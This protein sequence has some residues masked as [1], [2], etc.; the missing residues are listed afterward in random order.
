MRNTSRREDETMSEALARVGA[1][2][3]KWGA[4]QR[5]RKWAKDLAGGE[6]SDQVTGP[7]LGRSA[8]NR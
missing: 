7:L 3:D 6:P 2:I 1:A 5:L 4:E 8:E